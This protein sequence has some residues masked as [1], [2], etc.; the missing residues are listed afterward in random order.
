MIGSAFD[1]SGSMVL[2]TGAAGGIGR[3]TAKAL[4]RQGAQVILTDY[5]TVD[6][7]LVDE[8]G[9]Q[10]IWRQCDVTNRKQVEELVE[11][12]PNID[13]LVLG[14]GILPFDDWTDE[15]WDVSFD[16]VMSVNVK[17][18][19]NFARVY[20]PKMIEKKAGKIVVIGSASGRMGG[21][22]AGPHY[23]ASKGAVHALVRWLALKG[24]SHGVMINGIAPGSVDTNLL[25]GQEFSASKVPVGRLAKPEEIAW[26]IAFLCSPAASFLCGAVLDVNGGLVF[27]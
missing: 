12:F 19:L 1:L 21:M 22:Q 10:A 9:E 4:V 18:I 13:A 14:A 8:L 17:G 23:V 7:Q 24:A 11:E 25:Y 16:H 2:V 27:S 5:C 20:L 3:E 6:R 26:P 15:N